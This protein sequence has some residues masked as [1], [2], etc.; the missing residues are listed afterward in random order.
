MP[1]L[2]PPGKIISGRILIACVAV[3]LILVSA[4]GWFVHRELNKPILLTESVYFEV[5]RGD[6]LGSLAYSLQERELLP[7][8]GRLFKYYGFLTSSRGAI[9]A[10]EY[11]LVSGI[12]SF[13]LL[14]LFRSGKARQRHI[15]FPEGW[16]FSQW[17]S[18]LE[19]QDDINQTLVTVNDLDIM[20][21]LGEN[22]MH[23]EGQFFPDTYHYLKGETDLEILRRAHLRQKGVLAREWQLRNVG[24]VLQN[25]SDALILASIVE[26][27]TGYAPDRRLVARVFLNR[28]EQGMRLQSDPTVIYGMGSGFN[29]NL[30]TK[31]LRESGPY[32]TYMN[33]GLPPTPICMPGL[34][35]LQATLQAEPGEYL[36]FVAKGDGSSHFSVSL[37]EHNAAVR[38]YQKQGRTNDYRSAPR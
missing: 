23:V 21:K 7:V 16:T 12:D 35:A 38:R 24:D 22:K 28:L 2:R 37:D 15:T 33:K 4:L 5:K 9:K 8:N 32:N 20:G 18:Y 3:V 34:A 31:D 19:E 1:T 6:T 30:R 14:A 29:G 36:Y 13:G 10:G 25:V 26:K 17:R 11:E 27:E